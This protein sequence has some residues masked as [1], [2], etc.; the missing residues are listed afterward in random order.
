MKNRCEISLLK[1]AR[2]YLQGHPVQQKKPNHN[3]S[4]TLRKQ[5]PFMFEKGNGL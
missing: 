5:S 4:I 3:E 2:N 1:C